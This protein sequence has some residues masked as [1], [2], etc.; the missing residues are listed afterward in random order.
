MPSMLNPAMDALLAIGSEAPPRERMAARLSGFGLV[1]AA[2]S[3]LDLL[4]RWD[5]APDLIVGDMDSIAD[6]GLLDRYPRA[7][8]CRFSRDK[9]ETDA[10]IGLRML[11]ARGAGRIVIVGGGGGR[12]DHILAIRAL[13]ERSVR[14]AE[15]HTAA[16][17]VYYVASGER[18]S[19]A[20]KAGS[21]LSIF[22]LAEGA[23]G[24]KS[25]GLAWPLAGLSWGP[26]DFGLSNEALGD[27][28][29]IEAGKGA[30]LVVLSHD[31][32]AK[33]VRAVQAR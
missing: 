21:P 16:E 4:A 31:R 26:G 28:L 25:G 3:G 27:E 14:P 29:F 22:P 2:D 7:E 13:F 17:S 11:A 8:L 19:L 12:L 15:W 30:L 20:A 10:E 6:P 9:D 5:V 1:C 24:M 32:I 18:L 23:S 33:P